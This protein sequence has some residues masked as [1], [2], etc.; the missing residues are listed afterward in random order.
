MMGCWDRA[1]LSGVR[2]YTFPTEGIIT[3][4]TKDIA[5]E[6]RS[7][8]VSSRGHDAN[9]LEC[10]FHLGDE[11]VCQEPSSEGSRHSGQHLQPITQPPSGRHEWDSTGPRLSSRAAGIHCAWG[12]Y[13]K[14]L[15]VQITWVWNRTGS[16]ACCSP[17]GRRVRHDWVTELNWNLPFIAYCLAYLGQVATIN[18]LLFCKITIPYALASHSR[19]ARSPEGRSLAR[20]C[21]WIPGSLES[22]GWGQGVMWVGLLSDGSGGRI[23]FPGRSHPW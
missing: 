2:C 22:L 20:F 1:G 7:T 12:F 10:F 13:L 23:H 19:S 6:P 4:C 8:G 14:K 9:R 18:F 3:L 15:L 5:S 17:W 16:L 11:A 21:D